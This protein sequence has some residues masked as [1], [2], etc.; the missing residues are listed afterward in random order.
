MATN[1][2]SYG[3]LGTRWTVGEPTSK[4]L[5]DISRVKN[6]ANR[7]TL[8]QLITDPDDSATLGFGL[9]FASSEQRLL[10]IHNTD[11]SKYFQIYGG[12]A[13]S[14]TSDHLVF[15][16]GTNG[17]IMEF[18][19]ANHWITFHNTAGVQKMYYRGD[20]SPGLILESGVVLTVGGLITASAGI[21]G[22]TGTFSSTLGVT[23]ATTLSSDVGIGVA[24]GSALTS[25]GT[26]LTIKEDD[27]TNSANIELIGGNA[28][29]EVAGRIK[30]NYTGNANHSSEIRFSLGPNGADQGETM[31]LTRGADGLVERLKVGQGTVSVTGDL[32]VDTDTL[33]VDASA[34]RVGMNTSSPQLSVST[35]VPLSGFDGFGVQYS[36]ETKGELTVNPSTGEVRM[37]A[38]NSTGTYFTTLYSNGSEAARIDLSGNVGIGTSSPSLQ[39]WRTNTYLTID[40]GTDGGV[41]ELV[42]SASDASGNEAGAILWGATGNTTNHKHIGGIEMVTEGSTATQRGA[43]MRLLTKADGTAQPTERL[44]ILKDGGITFNGDT[45]AANALDDY[46]EGTWTPTLSGATTATIA[47]QFGSWYRKVGDLV[48]FSI[49]L[50]LSSNSDTGSVYIS[51]PFTSSNTAG[52]KFGGAYECYVDST[53]NTIWY[54]PA[55]SSLLEAVNRDSTG[56][57]YATLSGKYIQISGMFL[58]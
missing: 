31:F 46:E 30:A 7:W 26:T 14:P 24:A 18:D 44:R 42:T 16:T 48:M 1:P 50:Q 57:T 19:G 8:E 40:N 49:N 55:N 25:T 9:S 15:S 58:T 5:L 22:T 11:I 53:N 35:E 54:V 10:Q 37:G 23:G 51:L 6:D 32:A 17:T 27:N 36:N 39:T 13:G 38:T 34:D 56:T 45:A 52:K 43:Y 21:S 28:N 4:S 47:S 33:F 29:G 41:V 12:R 3:T 20:G 2:Y